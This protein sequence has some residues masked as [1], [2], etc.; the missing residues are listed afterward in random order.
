LGILES[1]VSYEYGARSYERR[2]VIRTMKPVSRL[3]TTALSSRFGEWIVPVLLFAGFLLLRLPFRA[4]FPVNWDAVQLALGTQSF[5]LHNHQPHPPGYI[6]LIGLGR[7]MN[8][9]THDPILSL[10]LISIV[11]GALVPALFYRFS[12]GW[13]HPRF[14]LLTAILIGVSPL[15]WYYSEVA[16]SYAAELAAGMAF[17]LVMHRSIRRPALRDLLLATL[18]LSL[19]GSLRQSAMVFL[20]PVWLF[21]VW[22]YPWRERIVAGSVMGS[23]TLLW[24][25][26]LIWL[27]GGPSAYMRESRALADLIG[28]QTSILSMNFDGLKM[29]AW[30][31]GVGL[32][33]GLHVG[34]LVIGIALLAGHR[35]LRLLSKQDRRLFTIW[36]LPALLTFLLG[37]TGQLGYV[38]LLLPPLFLIL[39]LSIEELAK[40]PARLTRQLATSSSLTIA[41]ISV[42]VFA[43]LPGLAY[44]WAQPDPGE[45]ESWFARHARQYDL[46]TSDSHWS[47]LVDLAHRF[48][49]DHT[50]ILTTVGGPRAS[51]S[52]RHASY[53]LPEYRVYGLGTDMSGT[54]GTLFV[55]ED[56]QSNYSVEGLHNARP[57]LR[58]DRDARWVIIPDTEILEWINPDL[59]LHTVVLDSGTEAAIGHIRPESA[60]TINWE[61]P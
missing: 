15:V 3:Q 5:N 29:N 18:L 35:P 44:S 55:A 14:A 34:L 27:S 11:A 30:Y 24:A 23:I 51:G 53:L 9:I 38:L 37:H 56:G 20:V 33:S 32:L 41:T 12:R 2:K 8:H 49:P 16:L 21:G 58:I 1:G 31:V 10:T 45:K 60:I 57:W 39:G 25:G 52:F 42:L 22:H 50:V 46:P 4:H 26:P 59:D 19:L 43:M 48:D 54:F 40:S 17:M 13:L 6:G 47:S 36:S 28:G 7:L 61:Q